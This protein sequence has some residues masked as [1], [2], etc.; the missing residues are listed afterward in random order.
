MEQVRPAR[1]MGQQAGRQV[2]RQAGR[3]EQAGTH[4]GGPGAKGQQ[5][6]QQQ[7]QGGR[8]ARRAPSLTVAMQAVGG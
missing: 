5:P 2:G 3:P 7:Q 8:V 6:Q 1:Q 4:V